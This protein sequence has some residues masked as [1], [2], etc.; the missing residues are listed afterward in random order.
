MS[1]LERL[2]GRLKGQPDYR[3][4]TRYGGAELARILYYRTLQV[5]RGLRHRPWIHMS[6][7]LLLAGRGVV[8]EHAALVH[9]GPQLI[10]EDRVFINALSE[11]GVVFGRNCTVGR[12]TVIVCTGVVRHK[13][14]G[15]LLGDRSAI[16]PQSFLGGQGGIVIGSDVIMGPGVRIF[17]ENHEFA[18]LTVP[19]R[20]QGDKREGVMIEDDCWIGAGVTIV[21]GVTVGRGTVVAAGAVVTR[22][23]PP[24]SL[25]AGVPA[26]VLR[27][28]RDIS[29]KSAL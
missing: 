6:G 18:D 25:A 12:D 15:L 9:A 16:G 13:G 14:V 11:R 1:I 27:N 26:R 5:G 19:I 3:L 24:Y 22:S 23:L 21:D 10:L 17:S 28:R 4:D 20:L 7:G 2:I 29:A 8:I